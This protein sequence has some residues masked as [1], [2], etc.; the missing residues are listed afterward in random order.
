MRLIA[1]LLLVV[2]AAYGQ[3]PVIFSGGVVNAAS[4][5]P[6]AR[7]MYGI[8]GSVASIFGHNLAQL[9]ESANSVPLPTRL[10][11]TSVTVKGMP[12]PLY[13]VSPDQINI[14]IPSF[15]A[16]GSEPVIV[17]ATPTGISDPVR[18][19]DFVPN[20]GIFTLDGSGCGRGVVLNVGSDGALSLNSPDN[21]ASPGESLAIFGT[22]MGSARDAPDGLPAPFN[23]PAVP[24]D[25]QVEVAFKAYY[26]PPPFTAPGDVPWV[27]NRATF[28]GRAPGLI[29]V[30]QV[31]VQIPE[32]APEG[33]AV[34]ITAKGS[35]PVSISIRQ[36]G[37]VCI[38]PSAESYGQLSW[39]RTVAIGTDADGQTETFTA[40]LTAAPGMEA[41]PPGGSSASSRYVNS[42]RYA[43]FCPTPGHRSLDAG[44]LTLQGPGFGPVVAGAAVVNGHRV[45]RATLPPGTI[46]P[47]L[48]QVRA[49]GSSDIGA[50]ESSL[51]IGS[52]I[53]VTTSLPAGTQINPRAPFTVNW[54]GGAPNARVTMNV[55]THRGA[56]DYSSYVQTRASAG[57]I[58]M[59]T[60]G[61]GWLPVAARGPVE[62]V[63]D[64][65]PDPSLETA[66]TAPGLSLGGRHTW[67]YTYRFGGLWIP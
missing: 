49:I 45:V 61:F 54:T 43:G 46:Q 47:G 31:N 8:S 59:Y 34:P 32:N 7:G 9:T 30:D 20:F 65:T 18:I 3:K 5:G 27:G 52:G 66:I 37:G 48:F 23:P 56:W 12:A 64:V 21:S 26:A 11:G 40:I 14:Q 4:Y 10:A 19:E 55:V 44:A 51:E 15:A 36:G 62:I 13:Y 41:P 29:G 53:G 22:G 25:T 42:P 24:Y 58:T 50:F 60:D 57:T 35:Q 63:L 16:P 38:D 1:L 39:E 2:T 17:V 6:G 67:K 28:V 33:C